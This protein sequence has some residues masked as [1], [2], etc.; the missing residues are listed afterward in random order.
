ML[1]NWISSE[2]K[3]RKSEVDIEVEVA[4]KAAKM[5]YIRGPTSYNNFYKKLSQSGKD[6]YMYLS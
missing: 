3:K 5:T 2:K 4:P 1:Q 6:I